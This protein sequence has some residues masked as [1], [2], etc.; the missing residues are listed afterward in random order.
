[1]QLSMQNARSPAAPAAKTILQPIKV[2]RVQGRNAHSKPTGSRKAKKMR[3][4]KRVSRLVV[5][6]LN[7]PSKSNDVAGGIFQQT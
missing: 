7:C 6:T 1:M 4:V 5:E 2:P 3:K